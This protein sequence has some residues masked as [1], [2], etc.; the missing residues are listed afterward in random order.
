MARRSA[1][2]EGGRG[3]PADDIP[4]KP[5]TEP[6]LPAVPEG[7]KISQKVQ[8]NLRIDHSIA[9]RIDE[10]ILAISYKQKRRISKASFVEAA[11][12]SYLKELGY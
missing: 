7:R 8:V 1:L 11:F 5:P 9:E 3:N 2:P 10:A 6:E 4:P 12:E